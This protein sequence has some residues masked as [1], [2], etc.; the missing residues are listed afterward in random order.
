MRAMTKQFIIV[1]LM[2]IFAYALCD[3]SSQDMES[4]APLSNDII[5]LA[6]ETVNK[7]AKTKEGSVEHIEALYDFSTGAQMLLNGGVT[8]VDLGTPE[9]QSQIPKYIQSIKNIA[10]QGT[11]PSTKADLAYIGVESHSTPEQNA[12]IA[13]L[14]QQTMKTLSGVA[15]G[16]NEYN[17]VIADFFN[18]SQYIM[19]SPIPTKAAYAQIVRDSPQ[20]AKTIKDIAAG[21]PADISVLIIGE[22]SKKPVASKAFSLLLDKKNNVSSAKATAAATASPALKVTLPAAKPSH[23][24][25]PSTSLVKAA[26]P[27]AA[28]QGTKPTPITVTTKA[29]PAANQPAKGIFTKST[30]TSVASTPAKAGAPAAKVTKR[31]VPKQIHSA[32]KPLVHV[33]VVKQPA[34]K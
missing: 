32:K 13:A 8:P 15:K 4:T 23:T 18:Q 7:L 30:K 29:A 22:R 11:Q 20:F 19:A 12:A 34:K 17:G 5:Q 33:T 28:N 2:Q 6:K 27:T 9:A 31:A 14:A 10:E 25:T 16:T 3:E 21:K 24:S 1:V 26:M